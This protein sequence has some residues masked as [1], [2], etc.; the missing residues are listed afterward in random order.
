MLMLRSAL[1]A[2]HFSAVVVPVSYSLACPQQNQIFILGHRPS[3]FGA[4][5]ED[6]E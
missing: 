2:F 1:T 5:N 4:R 6:S 3:F